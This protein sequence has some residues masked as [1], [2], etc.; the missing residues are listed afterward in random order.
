M[1]IEC[2]DSVR[3]W[4]LSLLSVFLPVHLFGFKWNNNLMS[5][6][7]MCENNGQGEWN[8]LVLKISQRKANRESHG[9]R[10]DIKGHPTWSICVIFRW[11]VQQPKDFNGKCLQRGYPD[12]WMWSLEISTK[13]MR[14]LYPASWGF[15]LTSLTLTS[16]S[17]AYL[18]CR[19]IC[20]LWI[21][22]IT[23]SRVG[24]K[25]IGNRGQHTVSLPRFICLDLSQWQLRTGPWRE[26]LTRQRTPWDIRHADGGYNFKDFSAEVKNYFIALANDICHSICFPFAIIQW[27]WGVCIILCKRYQDYNHHIYLQCLK[28]D[29]QEN[30]STY[31]HFNHK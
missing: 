22:N 17:V 9:C 4:M 23:C 21:W 16:N 2:Y 20:W 7:Q 1:K 18:V 19:A 5:V 14:R 30:I 3:K 8:F 10:Y 24:R 26:V 15:Y 6:A 31:V 28:K 27:G 13:E 25:H 12:E 11:S 29:N